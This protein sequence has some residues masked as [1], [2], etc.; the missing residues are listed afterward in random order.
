LGK[1]GRKILKITERSSSS[2]SI[3]RGG[4]AMSSQDQA[5]S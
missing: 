4:Q 5:C 2:F 3:K 1:S